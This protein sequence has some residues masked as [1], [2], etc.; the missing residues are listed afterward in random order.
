MQ[1]TPRAIILGAI[2]LPAALLQ[3]DELALVNGDV[4]Q[5]T[6]VAQTD[7]HFI[8]LSDNFVALTIDLKRVASINGEPL[9]S[10]S[11]MPEVTAAV[12]S[13]SHGLRG[14]LSVTGAYASGNEEREDWDIGTAVEWRAG[15][16]RH[17]AA[18]NYESHSLDGSAASE[19]HH[20]GYGL[21]FFFRE[22]W[23]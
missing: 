23:F 22:K 11:T 15:D 4:L 16:Y 13:L 21:D 12:S 3:A 1:N 10:S 2:L 5:G 20:V 14:E 6:T 7:S 19:E 18:I 9:F 17:D 8:W